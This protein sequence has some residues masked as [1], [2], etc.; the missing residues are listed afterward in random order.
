MDRIYEL[1]N[2]VFVDLAMITHIQLKDYPAFKPPSFDADFRVIGTANP[3]NAEF[4]KKDGREA[5]VSA[6]E[7]F[8]CHHDILGRRL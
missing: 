5:F 2:R 1:P 7:A 6:W 8:R 4:K 3:V